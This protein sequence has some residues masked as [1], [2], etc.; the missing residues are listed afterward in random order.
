METK[1]PRER[2]EELRKL[3][4]FHAKKYYEDDSPE[5]SDYE[6]DMLFREL[7]QLEAAYPE[8]VTPD[9]PTQR[10]GGRPSEK[11]SKVTHAVPMDSL[12]D[13]FDF[14][15][16]RAFIERVGVHERYSVEPKIDGL[17]VCLYYEG[18]R[19]VRGATRGDGFVG[20]D[21]TEN[22]LVVGGVPHRIKYRGVLDVRGEVYM[23]R[24]A[25]ERLNAQR[26]ERG[27]RLF[28]NPRNAAAGSLRQLDA[29]VTAE[30]GLCIY[31]FN[32]QRCDMAFDT[33][34]ETLEFLR[35][36]GFPV[37]PM[38]R[39]LSGADAIVEAVEAIDSARGEL[40]CDIDGAVIK[41]DNIARRAELGWVANR[42]RWAVAYKYP[43]EVARTRL[44]DIKVNVGR[45]GVLTPQAV[46][47]PVRLAGTTVSAATLHNLDL[48]RERDIR[49]GDIVLV[50]KAGEIIPEIIGSDTERRDGSEV[51][52]EMPEQCPSCREPVTRDEGAAAYR[53]TN[54]ACPAQLSRSIEYFASR[55]AM[56]IEGLGPALVN[57]LISTG[58]VQNVADLYSLTV[59]QLEGLERMGKKSAENLVAAI[60]ASKT[61]GL[62]RLICALGIRQVGEAAAKALA[63]RFGSLDAVARATE[64]ELTAIEDIGEITAKFIR[65]YF[66][67]PQALELVRRLK[68]AG[69]LTESERKG[70][71][72]G[73]L[74]GL[75]FVITGTLP[76]MTRSEATELIEANGGKTASS[77]SKKTS[78]VLAGEEAGSKLDKARSLGVPVISLDQL[79]AMISGTG[80]AGP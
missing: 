36:E 63:D 5:I 30:R 38:A 17:S 60:E 13:V 46:L 48:I 57:Q 66:S 44:L 9:S 70:K 22:L 45:T 35:E 29:T 65:D 59:E 4:D 78:Y 1:N 41:L 33:H 37:L 76:G 67:H 6:Y 31:A 52:F 26:E 18:G 34:T 42:P 79:R 50:R 20:E 71:A 74:S 19:L 16:L 51:I 7:E 12:A 14:G 54:A 47:E 49:V 75:T 8:L 15:E 2:I 77:V 68:E 80:Q 3:I 73:T 53:C 21:V 64:E 25:F 69:V 62:A 27:E 24:E 43:P 11:F 23:P 61:R 58:L 55:G 32:I 28:A 39:T 72:E 10:V 56:N 40:D